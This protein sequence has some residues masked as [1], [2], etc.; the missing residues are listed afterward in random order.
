MLTGKLLFEGQ[1]DGKIM[2]LQGTDTVP[3]PL[4][5]NPRISMSM[6][7][8]LEKMLCKS[9]DDRQKD[10]G[11]VRSDIGRVR[12]RLRPSGEPPR[13]GASTVR[14]G[15]RRIGRRPPAEPAGT[16]PRAPRRR[17]ALLWIL[18]V[19]VGAVTAAFWVRPDWLPFPLPWAAEPPAPPPEPEDG[20]RLVFEEV[21]R[22]AAANPEDYDEAIKR[23]RETATRTRGTVY[24]A[25]AE[26]E[27]RKRLMARQEADRSILGELQD[28]AEALAADGQWDQAVAVFEQYDGFRAE[29]TAKARATA[30][31]EWR[32]RRDKEQERARLDQSQQRV[33]AVLDRVAKDVVAQ[34]LRA[35]RGELAKAMVR[36]ETAEGRDTLAALDAVLDG[37]MKMDRRVLASFEAQRGQETTLHLTSGKVCY[38]IVEVN[39]D[40]IVADQR[41][42]EH[43]AT[44]RVT[45]GLKDLAPQEWLAR[46]GGEDSPDVALYMG[47]IALRSG[48]TARARECFSRTDPLIAARLT[49]QVDAIGREGKKASA[50]PPAQ[51]KDEEAEPAEE[52]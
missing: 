2:E 29:S 11:A 37:V 43:H 27:I 28:K 44:A 40:R 30:A 45:F 34:N 1:P 33:N 10:W 31:D 25:R 18:L 7:W 26:D 24:A 13:E 32:K 5:L 19:L 16:L 41:V 15:E 6:A 52:E 50:R 51:A 47:L 3:D 49:A 48:A 38:R 20:A 21:A 42:P 46:I 23:F 8:M 17:L 9:R 36:P 14:R 4:D 35:A 12:R 39:G 22:W